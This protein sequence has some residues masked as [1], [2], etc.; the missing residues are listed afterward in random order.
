MTSQAGLDSEDV[1]QDLLKDGFEGWNGGGHETCVELGAD[2]DGDEG[3]VRL[4][5]GQ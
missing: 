3:T 1:A 5:V 4:G 2:P